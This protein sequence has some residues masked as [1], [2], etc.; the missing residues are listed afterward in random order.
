[1][2]APRIAATFIG[3]PTTAFLEGLPARDLT[4]AE[5][6]ALPDEDKK[7]LAENAA[8]DHAV[9][10]LKPKET[11]AVAAMADRPPA[12]GTPDVGAVAV[13]ATPVPAA[14]EAAPTDSASGR[15]GSKAS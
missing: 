13:P 2:P 15:T 11:K 3:D 4:E 12:D 6:D 9:Y 7:R 10:A 8:S 1:M 5:F 14:N